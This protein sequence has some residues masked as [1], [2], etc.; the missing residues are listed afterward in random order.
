MLGFINIYKDSGISSAFVVSRFKKKVKCKCGHMGTLDPLASGVLPIGLGQASR[1][2]DFLL[3]K[4]KTYVAVFDFA[5]QTP[6]FDLETEPIK[7]ASHIPTSDEIKAVLPKFIGKIS[8]TPPEYSAKMVDG[9]RCYKLARKGVAVEIPPKTVEILNFSLLEQVGESSFKFQIDCKGGTYIRSLA[10]DLGSEF[11]C[12]ATMTKLERTAAGVFCINNSV[13]LR[14][15]LDSDNIE[16]YLIK[17]ES[18][19]DYPEFVLDEN[20]AKRLLNG[21]YDDFSMPNGQYK[22]FCE[23]VFWG[24]GLVVD[25]KL[26]M[27]A[28]VRENPSV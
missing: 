7:F 13:S 6:S 28:Y 14:E 5:F 18:V 22:V 26:K 10:R 23:D 24:V 3:D 1:L 27:K 16:N 19:L 12:P 2:F 4:T 21:L 17:P 20:H 9:K 11:S 8:Q 25:G 15:F